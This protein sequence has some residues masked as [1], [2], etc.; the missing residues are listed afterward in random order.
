[1][2][3]VYRQKKYSALVELKKRFNETFSLTELQK[4]RKMEP[5]LAKV[6][7]AT[8]LLKRCGKPKDYEW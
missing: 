4:L 7:G 2:T 6:V 3:Y 5:K 8:I 1:M